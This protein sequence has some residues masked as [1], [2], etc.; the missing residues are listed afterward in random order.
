M[1]PRER[2]L[3]AMRHRK[4]DRV[5]FFYRDEPE[6]EHRLL[7]DLDLKNREALLSY[8]DIDFRWIGPEYIGPP[9]Q[10][11]DRDV[12]KDIWGIE[13]RYTRFNDSDGY[14]EPV[15]P[16]LADFEN[17]KSLSDH[18]WPRLEWFDFGCIKEKAERY[19]RYALMTAP[20][21]PSPGILMTVQMLMGMEKAWMDMIAN[22]EFYHGVVQRIMDFLIP[23]TEAVL[24]AAEGRFDFFRVGDDYGT[25]KGLA[26]SSDLWLKSIH[27]YLKA[28]NRIA[29]KH[30]AFCYLHSCGSVR[31]LIPGLIEAGVDVL[32]PVQVKAHRMIPAELKQEFLGRICFSGG[33]DEQ[34]LLRESTPLQVREAVYSL[35]NDMAFDGGFFIGPTHNFQV[36]IP[37]ANIRAMYEAAAEWR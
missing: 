9:L 10:G 35:L 34:E 18:Q 33:V 24:E 27:P 6:V 14:W 16:P 32:D 2:V 3:T 36:D 22:P 21:P 12:K 17:V 8:F 28:L 30:G 7:K 37:T 20:G 4:P 29:K 31:E 19:D 11:S 26:L 23:F 5:P 1:T 15:S 13:Y 25:Q